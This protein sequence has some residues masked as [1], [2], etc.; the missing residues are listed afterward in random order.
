MP[1][2]PNATPFQRFFD[3]CISSSLL[4][5]VVAVRNKDSGWATRT[6]PV[7]APIPPNQSVHRILPSDR[8]RARTSEPKG[9]K[10]FK[11]VA[12]LRDK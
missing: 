1:N 11:A 2:S 10:K 9:P 5:F 7:S 3:V 4:P 8:Y 12:S 6:T